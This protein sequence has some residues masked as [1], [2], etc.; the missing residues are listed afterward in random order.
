ME[1]W[2]ALI[3][4]AFKFM[5]SFAADWDCKMLRIYSYLIMAVR[6][7]GCIII[8]H[9]IQAAELLIFVPFASIFISASS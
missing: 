6:G 2:K 1:L 8:S 9:D 3:F 5:V 4:G 7:L